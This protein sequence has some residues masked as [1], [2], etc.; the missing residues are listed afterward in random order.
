MMLSLTDITDERTLPQESALEVLPNYA[1][2][3]QDRRTELGE[4]LFHKQPLSE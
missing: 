4:I 3:F 1:P 2:N